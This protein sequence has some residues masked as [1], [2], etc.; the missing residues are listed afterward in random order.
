MLAKLFVMKPFSSIISLTIEES[1]EERMHARQ[2]V[3]YHIK[4]ILSARR[5][6]CFLCN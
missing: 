5:Q 1:K 2:V 3:V 4:G 6:G